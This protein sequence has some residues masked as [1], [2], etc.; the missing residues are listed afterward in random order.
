MK[1]S[2]SG[3]W[4][5]AAR[6]ALRAVEAPSLLELDDR[7]AHALE[8]HALGAEEEAL[9]LV[10][11][12]A[13]Q[14][15]DLD[16]PLVVD[17]RAEEVVQPDEC[18]PHARAE[19]D[20]VVEGAALAA[21]VAPDVRLPD[22]RRPVDRVEEREGLVADGL[23]AGQRHLDELPLDE[24]EQALVPSGR[25]RDRFGERRRAVG[26]GRRPELLDLC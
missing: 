21:L 13:V 8:R 24:V 26:G 17:Q 9:E 19:E 11:V 2:T 23:Q 25:P 5:G 7:P 15:R 6:E 1:W 12:E 3:V 4:P 14:R 18:L 20:A 16:R 22:G 10:L